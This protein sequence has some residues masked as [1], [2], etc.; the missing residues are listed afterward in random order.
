MRVNFDHQKGDVFITQ[1]LGSAP[2][3][4]AMLFRPGAKGLTAEQAE[5]LPVAVML[6]FAEPYD[7]VLQAYDMLVQAREAYQALGEVRIPEAIDALLQ[8]YPLAKI[9][10]RPWETVT[11]ATQGEGGSDGA[12]G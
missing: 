9:V 7:A 12:N 4:S 11:P 6:T 5:A 2:G 3:S 10:E 1:H 8:Q